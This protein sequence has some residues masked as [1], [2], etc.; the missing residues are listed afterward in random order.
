MVISD[1]IF[2]RFSSRLDVIFSWG[3]Y[4]AK[5]LEDGIQFSVQGFIHTGDV[6]VIK[7]SLDKYRVRTINADGSIKKELR[8]ISLESLV[9]TID[10]MVEYCPSY[11][12]KVRQVYGIGE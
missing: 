9:D 11:E 6:I 7:D 4:N 10:S 3:F 8:D 5:P 12:K 1:A 2:E